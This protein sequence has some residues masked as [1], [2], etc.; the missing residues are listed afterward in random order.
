MIPD[1]A[2]SEFHPEHKHVHIGETASFAVERFDAATERWDPVTGLEVVKST[3]CL[4]DVN[5]IQRVSAD[6]P[7]HYESVKSP[8]NANLYNDCFADVQGIQNGWIDRYNQALPG[9]EVEISGLAPGIYRLIT[10]VNPAGWFLESDYSNNVGWTSFEL[11][12]E[13]SG[14]AKLRMIPGGT[15]GIWFDNTSNGMG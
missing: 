14:N 5:R 2:F 10:M 12:R 7:D 3:F 4:I 11:S 1:A 6:D 13:S 9:Q 15:G 8:A